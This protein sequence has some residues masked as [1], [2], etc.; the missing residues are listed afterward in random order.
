ME[1]RAARIES[2][3]QARPPASSRL[4][5][6]PGPMDAPG[7]PRICYVISHFHPH[8]SGAERQA[9]AQGA[10]LARRGHAV[11]VGTR[12]IPGEPRD[13]VLDG[14]EIHRWIRTTELGPLF[15]LSFVAGAIRALHRL[16]P[17]YD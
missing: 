3:R 17:E 14:V 7:R 10:E 9:L 12:S 13:D 15:G 6:I 5:T 11:R 1:D 16:R 8:A 2:T 4:T